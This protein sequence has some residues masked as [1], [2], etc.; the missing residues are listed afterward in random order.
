MECRATD[1]EALGDRRVDD[2]LS[3]AE[4]CHARATIVEQDMLEQIIG[5]MIIVSSTVAVRRAQQNGPRRASP[6]A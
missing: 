1:I 4:A 2:R 3:V 5:P 6:R